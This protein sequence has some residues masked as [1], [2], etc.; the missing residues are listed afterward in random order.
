[1]LGG[2]IESLRFETAIRWSIGIAPDHRSEIREQAA[3]AVCG[4]GI[5]HDAEIGGELSDLPLVSTL[6]EERLRRVRLRDRREP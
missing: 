2:G 5:E 1:M 4:E 3:E 6:E